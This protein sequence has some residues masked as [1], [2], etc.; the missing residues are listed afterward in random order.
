[1]IGAD[2]YTLNDKFGNVITVRRTLES[3]KSVKRYVAAKFDVEGDS[4]KAFRDDVLDWI[5]RGCTENQ[6][7][8][9]AR[10]HS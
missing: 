10:N 8:L 9:M 4:V 7:P 2:E 6:K 5:C 1:M 3:H